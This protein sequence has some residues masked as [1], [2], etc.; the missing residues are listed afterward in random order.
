MNGARDL[1]RFTMQRQ[2]ANQMTAEFRDTMKQAIVLG[3]NLSDWAHPRARV[4]A[5]LSKEFSDSRG[6]RETITQEPHARC[7]RA[8][9]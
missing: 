1:S 8:R 6:F 2:W 7:D 4:L 9:P 5:P 3:R